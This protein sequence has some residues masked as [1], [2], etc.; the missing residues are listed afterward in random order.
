MQQQLVKKVQ[1]KRQHLRAGDLLKETVLSAMMSSRLVARLV[2]WDSAAAAIAVLPHPSG[3]A[4]LSIRRCHCCFA[5]CVL[6][7][8]PFLSVVV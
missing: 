5:D 3:S 8:L 7:P 2:A 4:C 6:L 1:K